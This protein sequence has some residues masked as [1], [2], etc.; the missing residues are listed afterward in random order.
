MIYVLG[1]SRTLSPSLL[2][3][4]TSLGVCS[5]PEALDSQDQGPGATDHGSRIAPRFIERHG[6][7][8]CF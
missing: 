2:L 4:H 5:T 1:A 6:V 3:A 8:F 7:V